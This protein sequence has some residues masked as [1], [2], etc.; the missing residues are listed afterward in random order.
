MDAA[1][2]GRAESIGEGDSTT[3]RRKGFSSDKILE[4]ELACSPQCRAEG[5]IYKG[6]EL[7][8]GADARVFE[9]AKAGAVGDRKQADVYS[10]TNMSGRRRTVAHVSC[11]QSTDRLSVKSR[12]RVVA[13]R[14]RPTTVRCTVPRQVRGMLA[15]AW[16]QAR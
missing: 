15:A 13:G 11:V 16:R 4:C 3:I 9:K 7:A 10:R 2:A 5:W 12:H 14:H 1:S 6:C 8:S